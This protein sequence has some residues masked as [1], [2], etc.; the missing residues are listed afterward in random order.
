MKKLIII[1]IPLIFLTCSKECKIV[2][3]IINCNEY[4]YGGIKC[5][6]Q[7]KD[8]SKY[9]SVP[10]FVEIGDCYCLEDNKRTYP[11]RCKDK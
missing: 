2:K 5:S 4:Y 11:N 10:R 3:R 7:F 9:N 8:N 1:L 6:V